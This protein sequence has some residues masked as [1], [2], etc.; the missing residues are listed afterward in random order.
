MK[1]GECVSSFKKS[2][3]VMHFTSSKNVSIV[4]QGAEFWGEMWGNARQEFCVWSGSKH[5]DVWGLRFTV[6]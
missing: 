1:K 3:T 6:F 5:D 4:F 2:A